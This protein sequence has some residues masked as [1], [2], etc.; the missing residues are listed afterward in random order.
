VVAG[1][2]SIIGNRIAIAVEGA[3]IV[4]GTTTSE[5]RW[6]QGTATVHVTDG[7]LTIANAP[8]A[9]GNKICFVEITLW[10]V[11]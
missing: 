8:G 2:P 3:V 11:D 10:S 5:Q 7:R 4:N 1:D 6:L 9:D